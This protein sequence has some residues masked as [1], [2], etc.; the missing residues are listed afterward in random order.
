[1]R[2]LSGDEIIGYREKSENERKVPEQEIEL[3]QAQVVLQQ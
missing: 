2:L 3:K 1:M